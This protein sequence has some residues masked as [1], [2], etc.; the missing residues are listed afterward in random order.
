[1]Q[2][3]DLFYKLAREHEVINAFVYGEGRE[4]G[5]ANEAHPLVWLD[6]PIHGQ[7]D[8]DNVLRYTANLDILGIPTTKRDVLPI[9]SAAFIV[10]LEFKEKIA[11]LRAETGISV[12]GLSFLTLREY[13]DNSAAGV[14]FTYQL[15]QA[16]PVDRCGNVF[17]PDKQF[18]SVEAL[19]DFTVEYPDGYAVFDKNGLP[20]FTIPQ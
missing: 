11:A 18:K 17:N 10:G 14:R 8:G 6:D 13:Y 4:K 16:N 19:P 15:L 12:G 2:I 20:N 3:V 1:M 9:Q 7:S 5:A